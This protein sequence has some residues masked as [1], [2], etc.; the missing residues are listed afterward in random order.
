MKAKDYAEKYKES[1]KSDKVLKEIIFSF[2]KEV[3][4]IANARKISS[5]ND[6]AIISIIREVDNKWRAF[7]K[8]FPGEINPEGFRFFQVMNME[9]IRSIHDQIWPGKKL[10]EEVLK[11]LQTVQG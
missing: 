3:K 5:R 7:A 11:E 6:Q 1:G 4:E 8:F 10:P 9:S 2:I